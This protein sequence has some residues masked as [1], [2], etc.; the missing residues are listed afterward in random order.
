MDIDS[1]P[2]LHSATK[3]IAVNLIILHG[4]SLKH[5]GEHGEKM[6]QHNTWT[7][8]TSKGPQSF[9][10]RLFSKPT[11]KDTYAYPPLPFRLKECLWAELEAFGEDT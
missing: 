7:Y 5:C 8:E 1:H 10:C 6:C 4:P 11:E 9:E 3:A 2:Y